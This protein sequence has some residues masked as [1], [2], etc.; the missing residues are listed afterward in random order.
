MNGIDEGVAV[1]IGYGTNLHCCSALSPHQ[2][3][4]HV[5]AGHSAARQGVQSKRIAPGRQPPTMRLG[6][7]TLN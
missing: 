5:M 6:P 3:P 7:G 2:T 4:R 1:L